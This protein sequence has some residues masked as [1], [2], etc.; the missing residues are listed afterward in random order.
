MKTGLDR[1]QDENRNTNSEREAKRRLEQR[2]AWAR[3]Q[4]KPWHGFTKS[5]TD[6]QW[7]RKLSKADDLMKRSVPAKDRERLF[8]GTLYEY[9]RECRRLRGLLAVTDPHRKR[10]RWEKGWP[11]SFD[12]LT[13]YVVEGSRLAFR[14]FFLRALA[15]ELVENVPFENV[16]TQRVVEGIRAM[17]RRETVGESFLTEPL[18]RPAEDFLLA[19][20]STFE[21]LAGCTEFVEDTRTGESREQVRP[22]HWLKDRSGVDGG[23][24]L[25]IVVNW[26]ASDPDLG[27]AFKDFCA[28]YRPKEKFPGHGMKGKGDG[29][30]YAAALDRLSAMRLASILKPDEAMR[31]FREVALNSRRCEDLGTFHRMRREA[32]ANFRDWFGFSD[33]EQPENGTTARGAQVG[34]KLQGD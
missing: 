20:V 6:F 16:P 10:A 34:S 11:V 23:E 8:L 30:S 27:E 17:R 24:A 15:R 25:A 31:R 32:I 26:H 12:G 29:E 4:L 19:G 28:A 1:S 3:S 9:A 14:Y 22:R 21:T 5:D 7:A 33:K 2:E 13:P 18:V